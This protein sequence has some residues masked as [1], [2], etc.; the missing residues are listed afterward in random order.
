[1]T[2]EAVVPGTPSTLQVENYALGLEVTWI[3]SLTPTDGPN[4][5]LRIL[6]PMLILSILGVLTNVS[7][8]SLFKDSI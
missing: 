5:A 4:V 2:L 8:C 3:I 6:Q 1:M 7:F